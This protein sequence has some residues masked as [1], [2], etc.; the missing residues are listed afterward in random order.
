MY[1]NIPMLDCSRRDTTRFAWPVLMSARVRDIISCI[2][3]GL[4]NLLDIIFQCCGGLS[5]SSSSSRSREEH[6]P[7]PTTSTTPFHIIHAINI[8]CGVSTG[9]W[10][11][12]A[13]AQS[14][15]CP[16]CIAF[17]RMDAL[18]GARIRIRPIYIRARP[19]CLCGGAQ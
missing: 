4:N 7:P 19:S 17:G 14:P 16:L 10:C 9:C 2:V 5:P 18:A 8:F 3:F 12:F 15:Q 11:R 6:Y 1:S 13:R